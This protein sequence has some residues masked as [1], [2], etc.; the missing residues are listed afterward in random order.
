MKLKTYQAYTMAE[1][2]AAVKQDLG[3][4]AVILNTRTF[5][6]SRLLGLRRTTIVEVTATTEPSKRRNVKT[7]TSA[8]RHSP[9]AGSAG[10]SRMGGHNEERGALSDRHLAAQRAYGGHAMHQPSTASQPADDNATEQVSDQERT[11]RFAQQLLE[12]KL[13]GPEGTVQTVNSDEV[14][15]LA[16]SPPASGRRN[17]EGVVHKQAKSASNSPTTNKHEPGSARRFVLTPSSEQPLTHSPTHPPTVSPAQ[18]G[19]DRDDPMQEELSAI[20]DMVGRVLQ[21]QTRGYRTPTPTM[22]SHLFDMY[23]KLI[24]QDIS[25]ELADRVINDV[26]DELTAD[27]LDDEASI[28]RAVRRHLADYIPVAEHPVPDKSPDDRPLTIALIGPTGVGKTTTL[29]KL[30]ATFKLRRNMRVGLITSDTYRIAAVD[31]LRT[32]ANIIGVPLEVVLTPAEMQQ[33]VHRLSDNDVLLLDTAGR[34]QNDASRLDELKMM[35]GACRPHEV[36]LVLS[37]TASEKVLLRE[38]EA[39]GEIG[40]DKIVLTKLDEAVSF[41]ML[42]NVMRLLGKQLSFV[43][44]GQ[45]VP[46]HIEPGQPDRL[47]GLV[48][49]E[50]LHT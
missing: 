38:A 50:P 24:G 23:L 21:H 46:D 39:F 17:N 2:L 42:V 32:Y 30:A 27:E 5:K 48:L 43:T 6:R 10:A 8:P 49:G 40:A 9:H 26:R 47:A 33:A 25:E 35:I 20:R 44:T 36:H 41:G 29:A 14:T 12:Q 31:Q 18:N 22:P 4:S 45:E 11:R 1:A 19:S 13:G 15:N 34:S 37:G 7:S 16:K 28:R 3:D